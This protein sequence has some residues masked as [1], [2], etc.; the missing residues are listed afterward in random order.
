MSSAEM[1]AM[2]TINRRNM[3]ISK[4]ACSLSYQPAMAKVVDWLAKITADCPKKLTLKPHMIKRRP[5]VGHSSFYQREHFFF[6][7]PP[8]RDKLWRA[9][10]GV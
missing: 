8:I 6:F 9:R 5:L 10:A 4:I 1:A 7:D 3:T 2:A